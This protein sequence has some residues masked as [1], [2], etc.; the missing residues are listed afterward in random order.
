M[1]RVAIVGMGWWGKIIATLLRGNLQLRVVAAVEPNRAAVEAFCREHGLSIRGHLEDVLGDRAVDAVILTTPHRFHEAQVVAAAGAG[2]HV[3]CEKPLALSLDSAL[4]AIRACRAAG[5]R[6]GVGHERRFE[7]PLIEARR[8]LADG[9][10]GRLLLIEGN[11]SHDKFAALRPDNWRL[12]LAEAACGPMTATGIHML[13]FALSLGG[14]ADRVYAKNSRLAT[15]YESGDSMATLVELRNGAMASINVTLATPFHAR[16]TVFGSKG[17]IEIRDRSHNEAP[18]GW[19]VT[20]RISGRDY[21]ETSEWPRASEV[22]DNFEA[23]ARAI[24]GR[25]EDYPIPLEE[26]LNTVS[27]IEAVFESARTGELVAIRRIVAEDY[28]EPMPGSDP[29]KPSNSQSKAPL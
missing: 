16:Y 25:Q 23:F 18:T 7:P 1:I 12:S 9:F 15:D 3:F 13:D 29:R 20:K 27:T 21:P 11:Y 26:M 14:G 17:W 22:L 8:L 24:E 6:L 2:K 4:R 10:L 5:V 28:A 19:I